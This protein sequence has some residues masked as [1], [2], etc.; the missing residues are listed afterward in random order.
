MTAYIHVLPAGRA[1]V[2]RRP[3]WPTGPVPGPVPRSAALRFRRRRAA[4]SLAAAVLLGAGLAVGVPGVVPLTHS[5]RAPAAHPS[6][7]GAVAAAS[8]VYIVRPGDTLW[9]IARSLHPSGDV[10]PLVQRLSAARGDAPLQA[11]ERLVLPSG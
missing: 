2:G 4:V 5:G 3:S 8:T 9:Q 10:R 11:G 7:V 6:V 1:G